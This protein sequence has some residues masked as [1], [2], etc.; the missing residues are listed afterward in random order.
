VVIRAV[1]RAARVSA[2]FALTPTMLAAY[3]LDDAARRSLGP[4]ERRDLRDRWFGA[5]CAAMLRVFGLRVTNVGRPPTRGGDR[6]RLVVSNHRGVADVLVLLHAFGGCMVSRA[7]VAG[8]PLIGA[9]G[10]KLG[11]VFVDRADARSG[12]ATIRAM[13]KLLGGG[14]TVSIFPEGTTFAGDEVRP[15]HAGAF[16]AAR[17]AGAEVVPVGLAYGRDSE[18]AFLD[19]SFPAHVSRMAAAPPSL[20]VLSAGEPLE[21]PTGSRPRDLAERAREAVAREVTRAREAERRR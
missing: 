17:A 11:T 10:R 12:A 2:F 13:Q 7:D 9:A 19:E 5:W 14:E 8:W 16:V 3:S 18:A 21:L 4:R 1:R 15:F 20:V 6:G